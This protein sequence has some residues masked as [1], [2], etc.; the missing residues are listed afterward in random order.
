MAHYI[1]ASVASHD[2]KIES[3]LV[4]IDQVRLARPA[5]GGGPSSISIA[6]T[7]WLS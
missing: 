7:F 2:D 1:I 6:S 4:N 5:K 3:V